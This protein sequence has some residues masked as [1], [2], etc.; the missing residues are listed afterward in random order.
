VKDLIIE[1]NRYFDSVFLMRIS[2]ELEKLDGVTQAV[3]AMATPINVENLIKSGFKLTTDAGAI[4]PAD[5]IIAIDAQSSEATASVHHLLGKLLAG[6]TDD[7][8]GSPSSA[9]A[10]SLDGAITADPAI[11]LALISVPGIHAAREARQALQRGL[12]VML[13]SDNVTV[14]DEIALKN[15]AISRGVLMMGPDCGTAIIQGA[16]LGFANACRPGAVGIVGASGT[17][18]QEISS[19]VHQL[20]G[21]I[22]QAIGTGG[23]DLSADVDGRMTRFG[24]EALGDDPGTHVIVVVSKTPSPAVANKVIASLVATGKPGVVH[25]IG[26]QADILSDKLETTATLA[27]AAFA[28]LA[29]AG[30]EITQVARLVG[31]PSF[32][33]TPPA[34]SATAEKAK[35]RPLE[36]GTEISSEAGISQRASAG[37]RVVGFYCG[38]TLCQEAWNILQQAGLSI[39]SNVA[40]DKSHQIHAGED[41]TGHVVWDLGDDAFTVGKPHPMIEPSL[42]DSHVAQAGADPTVGMVLADCV[43]GFG[44]HENPAASL[45]KAARIAIDTAHSEGRTLRIVASVTGTDQDPQNLTRQ[46]RILEAAGVIVAPSNAAAARWVVDWMKGRSA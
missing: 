44:A 18:I 46:R 14:E 38:G 27:D 10:T 12:H 8:S 28:A 9:S 41:T 15:D 26:G 30:I 43:I 19:L 32:S 7:N 13:F 2:S 42:R 29:K 20:G 4:Q 23:R 6:N 45:A 21:G 36:T 40:V 25:F 1:R 39:V 34:F 33:G 5:L 22:S 24:I 11:H 31:L 37:A 16:A 35:Q 3:V 17:G